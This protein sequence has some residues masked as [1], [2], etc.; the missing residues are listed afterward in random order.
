MDLGGFLGDFHRHRVSHEA[1][2]KRRAFTET[3]LVDMMIVDDRLKEIALAF[4]Q[5]DPDRNGFV[6]QQELDDI[7]RESYK[8]QME[9]RHMFGLMKDFRSETN[10]ILV[11]Y[12]KFKKWVYSLL[13][14]R[15]KMDKL[16]LTDPG[17]ALVE[18][19]FSK[20]NLQS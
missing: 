9:R 15:K 10:K 16:K 19:Y 6:T 20:Q 4:R 2:K 14:S 13:Q 18:S 11:D 17:Q 3:E 12:G 8:I 5:I 7:F 1:I